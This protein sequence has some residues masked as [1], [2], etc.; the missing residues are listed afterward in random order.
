MFGT[1][2]TLTGAVCL[3]PIIHVALQ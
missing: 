1:L 3:P 2:Q